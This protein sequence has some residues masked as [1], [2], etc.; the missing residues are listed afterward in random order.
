[1]GFN[2]KLDGV[3]GYGDGEIVAVAFRRQIE[4]SD[5]NKNFRK[6]TSLKLLF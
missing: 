2:S 5:E 1:M 4:L 3:R 6:K